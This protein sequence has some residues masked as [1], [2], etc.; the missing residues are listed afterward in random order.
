M[1][2]LW[3]QTN[4]HTPFGAGASSIASQSVVPMLEKSTATASSS[5]TAATAVTDNFDSFGG[6]GTLAGAIAGAFLPMD[7]NNS[8]LKAQQ[9]VILTLAVVLLCRAMLKFLYRVNSN[10]I[11]DDQQLQIC[12]GGNGTTDQN[13]SDSVR[14]LSIDASA[15]TTTFTKTVTPIKTTTIDDHKLINR[16]GQ[17]KPTNI[18]D[19][20]LNNNDKSKTDVT[21]L[22]T[23]DGTIVKSPFFKNFK[24]STLFIYIITTPK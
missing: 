9:S 11:P 20:N 23:I 7:A 13:E 15:T 2:E 1:R 8:N 4:I 18:F 10:A 12:I 17:Q 16:P 6:V 5:A 21:S 19:Q 22:D 14:S 3:R 24:L